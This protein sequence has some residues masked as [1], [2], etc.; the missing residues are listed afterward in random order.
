[1]TDIDIFTIVGKFVV[2]VGGAGTIVVAL[3]SFIAKMWAK[4]FME[5]QKNQYQK[6]I[7]EYKKELL[8][9]LEKCRT[10]NE[11][12]LHK[13][14]SVYDEEFK[15]YRKIMPSFGRASK[16][17][18]DYLIRINLSIKNSVI[19]EEKENIQN[20][21]NNAIEKIFEFYDKIMEEG[22]FIEEQT[23]VMLLNFFA[24]CDKMLKIN[25]N[26]EKWEKINWEELIDNQI[27]EENKVT[28][29]LRKK[30]RS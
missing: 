26:P 17:V 19:A 20:Q 29:Y 22:I 7:E 16:S 2:A 12:I 28:C 8:I 30:I 14:I 21:Y 27:N 25:S 5:K 18:L 24:Y 4:W 13:E 3:S 1:M 10:L 15:I 6:E 9:E 11:K 23:Y